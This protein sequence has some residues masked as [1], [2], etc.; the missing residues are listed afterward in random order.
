MN[1]DAIQIVAELEC[2]PDQEAALMEQATAFV[3]HTRAQPGCLSAALHRVEEDSC[4][5]VFVVEFADEAAMQAH[6]DSEWR[7]GAIV[8]LPDL[9]VSW[10]RRF[11]M[12]RVA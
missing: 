4:R 2:K 6:L 12:R 10:P 7:Q 1:T 3:Q 11:S 5:F 9:L 8:Q